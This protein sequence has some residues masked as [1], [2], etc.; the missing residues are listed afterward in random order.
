M[1]GR[2]GTVFANLHRRTKDYLHYSYNLLWREVSTFRWWYATN[3]TEDGLHDF[4][5]TLFDQITHTKDLNVSIFD[6]A[7]ILRSYKYFQS[8]DESSVK[9]LFTTYRQL[10]AHEPEKRDYLTTFRAGAGGPFRSKELIPK[11]LVTENYYGDILGRHLMAVMEIMYHSILRVGH[12]STERYSRL[13][14]LYSEILET[15][16]QMNLSQKAYSPGWDDIFPKNGSAHPNYYLRPRTNFCVASEGIT[17]AGYDKQED[18]SFAHYTME[19]ETRL[20]ES[21]KSIKNKYQ[22]QQM[23]L[24]CKLEGTDDD[25]YD[26]FVPVLTDSGICFAF[27][28]ISFKETFRNGSQYISSFQKV[29]QPDRLDDKELLN[30]DKRTRMTIVLDNHLRRQY[31]PHLAGSF[32]IA[33]NQAKDFM[34]VR[35]NHVVAELGYHTKVNVVPRVYTPSKSADKYNPNGRQCLLPNENNDTDSIFLYQS[36][37]A[38]LFE[39]KVKAAMKKCGCTPWDY[40]QYVDYIDTICDGVQTKC[41]EEAINFKTSCPSC[42]SNCEETIYDASIDQLIIDNER[43]CSFRRLDH[44]KS[45]LAIVVAE[46]IKHLEGEEFEFMLDFEKQ[47]P[48][49]DTFKYIEFIRDNVYLRYV[50]PRLTQGACSRIVKDELAMITIEIDQ[51]NVDHFLLME[52]YT[53][54]AKIS[55]FGGICSLFTGISLLSFGELFF[56]GIRIALSAMRK[57]KFVKQR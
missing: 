47:K 25:C 33:F 36:Q 21:L 11:S 12:I 7:P 56:W 20:R 42:L 14:E 40:P 38:C 18:F 45:I 43:E 19:E 37:N 48:S 24:H 23:M 49:S 35:D 1:P 31:D 22:H 55:K 57:R 17:E 39:C 4:T 50:H 15:Y 13:D 30:I 54:S 28:A 46:Q 3:P 53:L 10:L 8:R 44:E 41:F 6:V 26:K 2:M 16:P 29:F 9:L 5:F 51:S 32:K 52:R 27:N 34:N